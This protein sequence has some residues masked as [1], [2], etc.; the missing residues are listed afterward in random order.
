MGSRSRPRA[1]GMVYQNRMEGEGPSRGYVKCCCHRRREESQTKDLRVG[2]DKESIPSTCST[3]VSKGTSKSS[4]EEGMVM[5][6][7]HT[8]KGTKVTTLDWLSADS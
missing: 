1:V 8:G 6:M 2:L 5:R 7:C 4:E 3:L